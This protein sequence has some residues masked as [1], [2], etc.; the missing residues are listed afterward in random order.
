M[1][2]AAQ[3]VEETAFRAMRWL[4]AIRSVSA[5]SGTAGAYSWTRTNCHAL[6]TIL[7]NSS[8]N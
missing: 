4:W 1:F 2:E 7:V 3:G 6:V 8:R 5:G